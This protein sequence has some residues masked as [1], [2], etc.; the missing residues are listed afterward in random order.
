M[1]CVGR[2]SSVPGAYSSHS[3]PCTLL[4]RTQGRGWDQVTRRLHLGLQDARRDFGLCQPQLPLWEEGWSPHISWGPFIQVRAPP[5]QHTSDFQEPLEPSPLSGPPTLDGPGAS[6]LF[7]LG[8]PT[9]SGC[10]GE[11]EE[12]EVGSPPHH[13]VTGTQVGRMERHRGSTGLVLLITCAVAPECGAGAQGS[14]EGRCGP[15]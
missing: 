2:G 7:P 14:H 1:N 3:W 5:P 8:L 15:P 11:A 12:S 10:L 13:W 6:T 4:G 9:P